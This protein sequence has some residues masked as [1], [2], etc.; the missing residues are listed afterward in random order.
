MRA[1]SGSAISPTKSRSRPATRFKSVLL[2]QP[3]GPNSAVKP[4]RGTSRLRF[5]ITSL[6]GASPT[7]GKRLRRTLMRRRSPPPAADMALERQKDRPFDQLDDR[8]E[9]DRVRENAGDVEQLEVQR[10]L[11][12]DAARAP[13][14]FGHQDDLPD[15][16]EARAGGSG[17][18]G[19]E[20]RQ[21]H[22]AQRAPPADPVHRGHLEEALVERAGALAHRD[23]GVR[24]LVDR[25]RED[26]GALDQPDPDVG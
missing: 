23:H 26:H 17:D 18:V 13:E 16:R 1:G 9:R 10:D 5:S 4:L 14:Q 15:Q 19:I 12:A 8:D 25:D 21:D 24:D 22:L 3:E 6:G 7:A 11:K 20:L 2:P